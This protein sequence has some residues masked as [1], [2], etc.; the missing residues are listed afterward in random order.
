[1]RTPNSIPKV[2]TTQGHTQLLFNF[3]GDKVPVDLL[4]IV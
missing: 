3:C 1:M 4:E 2:W